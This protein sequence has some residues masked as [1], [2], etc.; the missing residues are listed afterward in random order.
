MLLPTMTLI[1]EH[2][3]YSVILM[4]RKIKGLFSSELHKD[5]IRDSFSTEDS[6]DLLLNKVNVVTFNYERV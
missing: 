4:P 6:G 1:I 5:I 2:L 3:Y